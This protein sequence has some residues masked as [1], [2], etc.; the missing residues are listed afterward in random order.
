MFVVVGKA[1]NS[2]KS[3]H[4]TWDRKAGKIKHACNGL[5]HHFSQVL[6]FGAQKRTLVVAALQKWSPQL[7][8]HDDTCLTWSRPLFLRSTSNDNLHWI[9][10]VSGRALHFRCWTYFSPIACN[11]TRTL[12]NDACTFVPAARSTVQMDNVIRV[13]FSQLIRF[14]CADCLQNPKWHKISTQCFHLWSSTSVGFLRAHMRGA[15][16]QLHEFTQC[17]FSC[18]LMWLSAPHAVLCWYQV[19]AYFL[20]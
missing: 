9:D 20:T 1:I 15:V 17:K 12:S 6:H 19:R 13:A 5:S 16:L 7:I 2:F 10:L 11:E 4:K 3:W 18:T 14:P 8:I